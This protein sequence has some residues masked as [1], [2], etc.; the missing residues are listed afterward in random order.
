MQESEGG[1]GLNSPVLI[2]IYHAASD[3]LFSSV[4]L[5][6]CLQISALLSLLC[7]KATL[8]HVQFLNIRV[9]LLQHGQYRDQRFNFWPVDGSN[10]ALNTIIKVGYFLFFGCSQR[11]DIFKTLHL[12][13]HKNCFYA[14]LRTFRHQYMKAK[15]CMRSQ[16]YLFK[17]IFWGDFFLSVRTI[18]STASSAAPQIP[19]CR[20][21][22]GSNPGPLQLVHW[23][24]DALT[25]R[26]DLIRKIS[27]N[28]AY[29]AYREC[30]SKLP[31]I[32]MNI[33]EEGVSLGIPSA[34]FL[35]V[36]SSE[37]GV[38]WMLYSQVGGIKLVFPKR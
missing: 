3:N 5:D 18:F 19:L 30:S 20:Q 25:T 22:L 23:Q 34:N 4:Q 37:A 31:R 21:I 12:S 15:K 35:F 17:N 32:A 29:T 26:I 36:Q 6:W 16:N 2:L 28:Y 7:I 38:F 9:P 27:K 13:T 33:M 14:D 24:S 11:S 10:L 8:L 1:V